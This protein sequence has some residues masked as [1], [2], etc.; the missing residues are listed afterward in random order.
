MSGALAGV[1]VLDLTR[2]LPGGFCTG[3]LADFGADV[4][5]VEDT[6]LGDYVRWAPPRYE[7]TEESAGSA[8]FLALNRNKRSI[9]IDLKS[10]AGRDVLLRLLREADGGVG[11]VPPRGMG[12]PG[13]RY[14]RPA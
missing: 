5:K 7:G 4:L 8:L 9:R 10:D 2:L 3:L 13:G 14:E 6:G 11:G 12:R 1:R